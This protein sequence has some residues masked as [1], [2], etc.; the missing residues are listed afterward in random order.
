MGWIDLPGV[1]P[2]ARNDADQRELGTESLSITDSAKKQ[3]LTE[4]HDG[5]LF[6]PS[7]IGPADTGQDSTLSFPGRLYN[8]KISL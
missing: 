7:A 6:F 4:A 3:V 5:L 8:L 2:A 1:R